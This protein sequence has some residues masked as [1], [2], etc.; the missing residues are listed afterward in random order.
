MSPRGLLPVDVLVGQNIRFHRLQKGWSQ[1]RLA[2]RIGVAFQ[3]VQ[4]YEKG[5]NRVGAGRLVEIASALG[6]P[7][8]ALFEGAVTTARPQQQSV[9]ALLARPYALRLLQDFDRILDE[10]IRLALVRLIKRLADGD[11]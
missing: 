10:Q 8:V 1:T 3:Q 7:L 11:E 5:A 9:R 2:R 4:K 6:V